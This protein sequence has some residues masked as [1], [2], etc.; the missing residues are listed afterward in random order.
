[1]NPLIAAIPESEITRFCQRWHIRELALFGSVLRSDFGPDSDVDVLVTF[2]PEADWGLLE[3]VQMQQELQALFHSKIDLIS[4]RALERSRNW[5][6]RREILSTA[7]P[8]F[9]RRKAA[10]ATG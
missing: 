9:P 6:L 8:L 5:L 10:Y 4:R 2:A 3:H 7:A 1:M